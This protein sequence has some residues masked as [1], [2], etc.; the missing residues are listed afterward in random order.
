MLPNHQCG[1]VAI[2]WEQ[3]YNRRIKHKSI[4]VTIYVKFHTNLPGVDRFILGDLVP[5]SEMIFNH[6]LCESILVQY[7]DINRD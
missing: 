6:P 2:I 7:K 1:P 3:F 4:N 5:G